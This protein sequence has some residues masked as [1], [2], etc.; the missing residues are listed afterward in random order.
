MDEET[1]KL[2]EMFADVW[3]G[4]NMRI[5][6]D[7]SPPV[8]KHAH[9]RLPR[10]YPGLPSFGILYLSVRRATA[11]IVRDMYE[12]NRPPFDTLVIGIPRFG[13]ELAR[14]QA[15]LT[16]KIREHLMQAIEKDRLPAVHPTNSFQQFVEFGDESKAASSF[17]QYGDLVKWLVNSGYEDG[18]F[19]AVG[20]AFQAYEQQELNLGKEVE[21]YIQGRRELPGANAREPGEQTVD[22][23]DGYTDYLEDSLRRSADVISE[24]KQKLGLAPIVNDGG[25]LDQKERDSLLALVAVLLTRWS[26]EIDDD[27]AL[28]GKIVL[29][30]RNKPRYIGE[31]TVRK[32]LDQARA[33]YQKSEKKLNSRKK[34]QMSS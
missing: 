10:A 31:G 28:V 27:P 7:V 24:L 19:L 30:M 14:V 5:H 22:L 1:P 8:S 16:P 34:A 15:E 13:K 9:G 4:Y 11:L 20:P 17:I 6:E 3:D 33:P 29:A 26:A 12:R 32:F 2:E 18:R 23:S 21:R 25:P